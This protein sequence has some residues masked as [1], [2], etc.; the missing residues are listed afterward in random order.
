[1]KGICVSCRF[2]CLLLKT[3]SGHK[4]YQAINFADNQYVFLILLTHIILCSLPVQL[5]CYGKM[6]H[7]NV[8]ACE[9][10]L[11]AEREACR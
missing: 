8:L 3:E 1:M 2:F 6:M 4:A 10:S 11:T 9:I 7:D 5:K